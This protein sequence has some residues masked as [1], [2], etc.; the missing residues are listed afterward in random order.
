MD[1]LLPKQMKNKISDLDKKYCTRKIIS[2]NVYEELHHKFTS[3][4][5]SRMLKEKKTAAFMLRRDSGATAAAHRT[6]KKRAN[7]CLLCKQIIFKLFHQKA[8]TTLI[9]FQRFSLLFTFLYSTLNPY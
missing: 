1:R 7:K 2:Q 8:S 9:A 5:S 3:T 6:H 4:Y